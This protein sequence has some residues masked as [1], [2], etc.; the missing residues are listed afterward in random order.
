MKFEVYTAVRYLLVVFWVITPS[1]LAAGCR[2][3]GGV[4]RFHR[5]CFH[6]TVKMEATCYFKTLLPIHTTS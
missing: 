6:S 2:R 3:F 5:Q 4:Y 1:R